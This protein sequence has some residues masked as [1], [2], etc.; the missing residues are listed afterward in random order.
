MKV[1]PFE[2]VNEVFERALHKAFLVGVFDAEDEFAVVLFGKEVGVKSGAESADM[3]VA[4]GGGGKA[5]FNHKQIIDY[6]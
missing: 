2:S 4:G 5:G 6:K 1:M 3:K